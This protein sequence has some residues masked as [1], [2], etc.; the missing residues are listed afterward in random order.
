[1]R[2]LCK[3]MAR[4]GFLLAFLFIKSKT[5]LQPNVTFYKNSNCSLIYNN[6]CF[7]DNCSSF[8]YSCSAHCGNDSY[9]IKTNGSCLLFNNYT[10]YTAEYDSVV[11]SPDHKFDP[12]IIGAL[13]VISFIIIVSIYRII[14][15]LKTPIKND[16][17][18]VLIRD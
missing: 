17:S 10:Y 4:W 15:N 8:N 12:A 11:N 14:K 1:M 5:A 13:G 18:N 7:I 2:V 9:I 16:I 6:V 3:L